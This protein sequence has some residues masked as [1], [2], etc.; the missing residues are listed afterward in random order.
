MLPLKLSSVLYALSKYLC[1][2]F[3]L[4]IYSFF[5]LLVK[6]KSRWVVILAAVGSGLQF[7]CL[8]CKLLM[9][10]LLSNFPIIWTWQ[11]FS[12]MVQHE[13]MF[14]PTPLISIL[15]VRMIIYLKLYSLGSQLFWNRIPFCWIFKRM[16]M[17][18]TL[19]LDTLD[20]FHVQYINK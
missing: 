9:I 8:T 6:V 19:C 4:F 12:P 16:Y 13:N 17:F 1:N 2:C 3:L 14:A 11:N 20:F 5:V 15:N 10:F 18:F 7:S